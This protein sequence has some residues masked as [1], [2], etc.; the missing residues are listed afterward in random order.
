[1]QKTA[2]VTGASSGVGRAVVIRL[3]QAG[4]EIAAVARRESALRETAAACGEAAERISIFPCDLGQPE[5][6]IEMGR[7]VLEKFR[8]VR[9]LVNA[10]GT[11]VPNRSLREMNFQTYR[12]ITEVN[13]TGAFLCVQSFLPGMRQQREGTIVNIVSDAGLRASSKA[14]AATWSPNSAWRGSRSRSMPR[15]VRTASAPAPSSPA[16]STPRLSRSAR[17]AAPRAAQVHASPGRC[18]RMRDAGG[19]PPVAGG[20][21]RVADQAEIEFTIFTLDVAASRRIIAV[22]PARLAPWPEFFDKGVLGLRLIHWPSAQI[23]HHSIF[24][25]ARRS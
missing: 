25:S 2:V 21:G 23:R 20:C 11:N 18:R 17:T 22:E 8:V 19:E 4:W 24:I 14:G 16:T 6:V 10:A 5:Q 1:M 12:L 13:L 7:H 15:S 3:A 9:V